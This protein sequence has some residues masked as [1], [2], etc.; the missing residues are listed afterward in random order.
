MTNGVR[1]LRFVGVE[2]EVTADEEGDLGVF[3]GD[4]GADDSGEGVDVGDGEGVVSEVGGG[5][6]EFFGGREHSGSV[7]KTRSVENRVESR[8]LQ[9]GFNCRDAACRVSDL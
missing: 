7:G 8:E 9:H 6:G 5:G 2:L 1:L 3:G 4:V